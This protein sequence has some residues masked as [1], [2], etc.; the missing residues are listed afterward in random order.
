MLIATMMFGV[1]ICFV[2]VIYYSM[3]LPKLNEDGEVVVLDTAAIGSNMTM[4]VFILIGILTFV[5]FLMYRARN[6]SVANKNKRRKMT[7]YRF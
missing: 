5:F 6:K 3:A 4:I 2:L 7:R 1:G